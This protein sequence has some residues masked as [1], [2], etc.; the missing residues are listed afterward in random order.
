MAVALSLLIVLPTLAQV[1]GDRSDGRLSVGSFLELRVADNLDDLDNNPTDNIP[2]TIGTI[3]IATVGLRNGPFEAQ[4]TYFRGDLYVSNDAGAYNTILITAAVLADGDD[5][6]ESLRSGNTED[7]PDTGTIDESLDIFCLG[8]GVAVATITNGRSN[9][10]VKAYLISTPGT[11]PA[12]SAAAGKTIYQGVVAVWNQEAGFDAHSGPC[13]VQHG[14]PKRFRETNEIETDN[15]ADGWTTTSAAVIP[16]RDGDTLT[17]K[18]DGVSGSIQVIVDGDAPE[19]D[20]TTPAHSGIQSSNNIDLG[21]NVSD[22]GSGL[23]YDG[24]SGG[25][26]DDDLQPHNGDN[27]HHFAEPIT[28][29]VAHNGDGATEDIKVFF[30]TD[31]DNVT[32]DHS[33]YGSNDWTQVSKG[34][35]YALDMRLV[36]N[37]FGA[38]Y[39]QVTATDRVGNKATTDSDEDKPSNQPFKFNV[40]DA[41]PIASTARTGIGYEAGEGEFKDRSWIALNFVNEDQPGEDRIDASTVAASDFTV[42]GHTVMNVIV[43]SDKQVCKGDDPQTDEKEDAKNITAYDADDGGDKVLVDAVVAVTADPNA[44]PPVEGVEAADGV[45]SDVAENCAF[46]P[47][48]RI[49]LELADELASDEEPTIQLLGG[50]FKDIAGNNNVTQSIDA[51]DK[52]APGVSITI[53]SSSGTTSRAATDKDGSFTVRVTSDE[54]LASF[55][56]LYFATIEAGRITEKGVAEDLEIALVS[57]KVNLTEQEQNTWEKK[58]NADSSSI[59]GTGDRI[60]AALVTATDDNR[61]SGNSSGWKGASPGVDTELDFKKLDAGGFLLEIDNRMEAADIIVLP[62]PDPDEITD[63]TESMNPYIQINFTE[64]DEYGIGEAGN[65]TDKTETGVNDDPVDC[66]EKADIGDGDSLRT[67]SHRNVTIT[68]L[69]LNGED[70]LAEAVQVDPWTYVLAV[71]GLAIGEYTITYAANDDVGNEVDEDD[72]TFDFEVLERQPYSITLDPG[73][74]LISLPGDPF[75]PA[76]G[77]VIGTDLKADTVLGYQSGEWVTAVR[78]EDGRWQGTL[79]DIQGGYG[80]WVRTTV[81]EDIETVIPPTLPTSVLPTVPIV[82][83]WNLVG[84]VDAAQRKVGE[85]SNFDADEY[86]TSLKGTWRVA[87]GFKTQLNRWDKLLPAP[88]K[89]ADQ[90][91]MENGKGYW[92][93]NTRSGILVP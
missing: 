23:R 93:W 71:T 22:D 11:E 16:A 29:G 33:Q 92:L 79:T 76:V 42:E 52:I 65:C 40:D 51:D 19:I 4:D 82:A 18:V 6:V 87:Y 8:D 55:P 27:D 62:S 88:D 9:T 70:R 59:P 63:R 78:N 12:G 39:W 67:D 41:D 38:Y 61:N 46:E 75:N 72:A 90:F 26:N 1:S 74:N 13:D 34:S 77:S 53:T 73:W 69:A 10:S 24:E 49:Y 60:V 32:V 45:R 31:E 80:Y 58:V 37:A 35:E 91:L 5:I 66:A 3:G 15:P 44:D 28:T 68:A 57:S 43:P 20:D 81:V 48:A 56:I 83:G 21:F 14:D 54:D 2:A 17:I 7:S 64:F 47:R 50:V 85:D 86:L 30:G 25:S 84:V 36:N 89:D